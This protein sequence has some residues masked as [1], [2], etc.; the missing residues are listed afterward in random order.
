MKKLFFSLPFLLLAIFSFA[1]QKTITGI[2]SSKAD[3]APLA[4]VTVQ[5]KNKTV[6]TDNAGKF[7]IEA[8]AGDDLTFS[9]VGMHTRNY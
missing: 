1:Q 7:S 8:S 2:V 4:G 5:T 6:L 9:Y 3:K